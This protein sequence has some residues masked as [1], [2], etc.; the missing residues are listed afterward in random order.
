MPSD[1]KYRPEG[2]AGGD[3]TGVGHATTGSV[4][5]KLTREQRMTL[6]EARLILNVEKEDA[7]DKILQVR[8]PQITPRLHG[9]NTGAIHAEVRTSVQAELPSPA[10]REAR[11]TII[12]DRAS[13]ILALPP[14]ESRACEGAARRGTQGVACGREPSAAP[15]RSPFVKSAATFVIVLALARLSLL[16]GLVLALSRPVFAAPR[17]H[18]PAPLRFRVYNIPCLYYR[19][20]ALYD[21]HTITT[22]LPSPL[23]FTRPPQEG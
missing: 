3:A 12:Q 17:I 1:A 14:V 20:N 22:V 9:L 7:A 16:L 8:R 11:T 21:L 23:R 19:P 18:A 5:D 6:D 10:T 13:S 15:S 4:T 2:A